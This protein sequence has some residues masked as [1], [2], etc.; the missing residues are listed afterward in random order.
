MSQKTLDK[1]AT[2]TGAVAG[3]AS[4]LGS[5]GLLNQPL[6][7]TVAGIATAVLG[8]LVQRPSSPASAD[9]QPVSPQKF[10]DQLNR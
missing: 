3:I 2:I 7:G 6:A 4:I 8:Y 9:Q 1:L 5:T 10:I